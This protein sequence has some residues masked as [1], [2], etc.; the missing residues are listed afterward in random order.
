MAAVLR[1]AQRPIGVGIAEVWIEY[2]DVQ[3]SF[4]RACFSM[5]AFFGS[6]KFPKALGGNRSF[7]LWSEAARVERYRKSRHAGPGWPGCLRKPHLQRELKLKRGLYIMIGEAMPYA[8]HF[9]KLGDAC[10]LPLQGGGSPVA[11]AGLL[12]ESRKE[13]PTPFWLTLLRKDI[14]V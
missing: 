7:R 14:I 10:I 12:A 11:V 5:P 1:V 3:C 2:D 13:P 8:I 6:R 9:P 4:F